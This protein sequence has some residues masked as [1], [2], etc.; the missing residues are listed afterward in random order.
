MMAGPSVLPQHSMQRGFRLQPKQVRLIQHSGIITPK[1]RTPSSVRGTSPA[2]A[3]RKP[4][5][6][7]GL[8]CAGRSL[9]N[10]EMV[11]LALSIDQTRGGPRGL[12]GLKQ[13]RDATEVASRKHQRDR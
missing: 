2:Y 12:S 9:S 5:S 7:L 10:D 11:G 6:T 1:K 3:W 13:Q 4:M 8:R